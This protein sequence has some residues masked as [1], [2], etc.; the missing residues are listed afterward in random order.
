MSDIPPIRA[1]GVTKAL[2]EDQDPVIVKYLG[3]PE[4]PSGAPIIQE[5]RLLSL[6]LHKAEELSPGL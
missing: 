2:H 5:P 4:D 3:T 6:L 1:G